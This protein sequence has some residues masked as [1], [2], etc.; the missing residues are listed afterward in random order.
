MIEEPLLRSFGRQESITWDWRLSPIPPIPDREENIQD[1]SDLYVD[2]D[3]S[4]I[5]VGPHGYLELSPNLVITSSMGSRW[6]GV[7]PLTSTPY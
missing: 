5:R 2:D 1:P 6:E 4:E 7:T 3:L